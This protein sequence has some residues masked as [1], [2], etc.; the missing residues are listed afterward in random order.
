[1]DSKSSIMCLEFIDFG[2]PF[3][4][5]YDN[6]QRPIPDALRNYNENCN[7]VKFNMVCS[8][9]LITKTTTTTTTM[10]K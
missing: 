8:T 5:Y 7:R 9:I 4:Y 1:M 2:I 6:N 3:V 10:T